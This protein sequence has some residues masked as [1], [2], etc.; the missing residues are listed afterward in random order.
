MMFKMIYKASASAD[1]IDQMFSQKL[2]FL[3]LLRRIF[4]L[5]VSVHFSEISTL[6]CERSNFYESRAMQKLSLVEYFRELSSYLKT[7][8]TVLIN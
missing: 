6:Y 8:Y 3:H 7:V 1:V 4:L 5:T 2:I